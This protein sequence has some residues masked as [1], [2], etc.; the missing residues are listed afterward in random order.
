MEVKKFKR[1][2]NPIHLYKHRCDYWNYFLQHIKQA[3]IDI[4][5][6]MASYGFPLTKNERKLASLKNKHRGRRCFIIGNGPSLKKTNLRLLKNEITFGVNKIYVLFKE[7]GYIP[8]YYTVVDHRDAE[9]NAKEIQNITGTIKLF[10][11]SLKY[12]LPPSPETIY[13]NYTSARAIQ[14]FSPNIIKY[15]Y[16]GENVIYINMQFAYYMGIREIYLIGTDFDW[17]GVE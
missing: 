5:Y 4:R 13:F 16:P 15:A 12:C 17:G 2:I 9:Y 11:E 3:P 8:T 7:L 6:Q 14:L 1:L 10:P